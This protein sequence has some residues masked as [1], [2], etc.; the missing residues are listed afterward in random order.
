MR[1]IIYKWQAGGGGKRFA[2]VRWGDDTFEVA[3][4]FGQEKMLGEWKCR[5]LTRLSIHGKRPLSDNPY[6]GANVQIISDRAA[7]TLGYL[8]RGCGELLPLKFERDRYWAVN[9]DRYVDCLDYGNSQLRFFDFSDRI[10]SID[11]FALHSHKIDCDAFRM[12]QIPSA[13]FVSA[14]FV[15]LANAS[16]LTGFDFEE[17]WRQ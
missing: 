1:T 13:H 16:G 12:P 7:H 6:L 9:I 4:Q 2:W 5:T 15:D 8:L 14:R 11:R 17:V 10:M 3:D